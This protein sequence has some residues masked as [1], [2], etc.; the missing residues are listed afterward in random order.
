MVQADVAP[1]REVC[2]VFPHLDEQQLVVG[3]A[4]AEQRHGDIA[5]RATVGGYQSLP[6]EDVAVERGGPLDVVH[7]Q[8]D[9]PSSLISMP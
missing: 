1:A 5:Q 9:M 3:A 4:A 6:S 7:V 2:G 8:D